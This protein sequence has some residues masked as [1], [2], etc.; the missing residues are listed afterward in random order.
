M[1]ETTRI[2]KGQ[3]IINLLGLQKNEEISA[4]LDISAA[5]NKYLFFVTKNGIVK[6]LEMD[7][8]KN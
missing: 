7:A 6:K 1:P 2:A 3:P 5:E 4:I 8:V